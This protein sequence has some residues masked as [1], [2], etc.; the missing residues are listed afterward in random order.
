[1]ATPTLGIVAA[2]M[3]A[4]TRNSFAGLKPMGLYAE[5]SAN[6][7]RPPWAIGIAL[8]ISVTAV[9]LAA[10]FHTLH[11]P[12]SPYLFIR[13]YGAHVLWAA[14]QQ[15][16]LQCFFLSRLLRLLPDDRS[17]AIAAAVLSA[18]VHLPSPLLM[19]AALVWGLIACL[20]FLRYRNLYSLI[21]AHAILGIAVAV[22][23]PTPLDHNMLVGLRY[24]TY[25]HEPTALSQP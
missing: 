12:G 10:A 7:F 4:I 14:I 20:I 19:L 25:E 1:M 18:G 8:A 9:T 22:S 2:S 23:V 13:H 15:L 5:N 21:M 6:F 17:A 3:L 16:G 24:L 11:L